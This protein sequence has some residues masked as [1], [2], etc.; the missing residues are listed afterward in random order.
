MS[1]DRSEKLVVKRTLAA[2]TATATITEEG[3]TVSYTVK[4]YDS[5]ISEG[6]KNARAGAERF[7][8]QAKL[9]ASQSLKEAECAQ[10]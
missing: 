6:V 9:G 5:L 1:V 3:I 4:T 10:E 7:L 8:W 2:A